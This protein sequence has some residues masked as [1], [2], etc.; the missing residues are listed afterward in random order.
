MFA[1]DTNIF[2]S[3]TN[4]KEAY[5]NANKVLDDVYNYMVTNQLHVNMD[6]SVYMH[7]RPSLNNE[8]RL[9][10]AR[11]RAYGS[12][13]YLKIANKKLK[14][15]DKVKFLGIIIDEQLNW[16]PHIQ[17]LKEKLN[18]AIIM[19]KRIIKFIPKSEY[20]K[21]YEGLFKSHLSYC[22][23]CW[24]AIPNSK[25]QG[26]FTIQKR[27]I[28]LLFGLKYSFDHAGYYETCARSR[29]YQDHTSPKNYVLEHTKS[30]FNKQKILNLFNLYVYHTFISTYKILKTRAPISLYSLFN[31][32][33]RDIGFLLHPP[34]VAL[35]ISRNN[36]V[37][38][39]CHL[40][41]KLIN[42]ILEKSMPDDKGIIIIGSSKNSDFCASIPFVQQKLKANL[43]NQQSQGDI[44]WLPE[45]S[46]KR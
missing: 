2:V 9:T 43:L 36:F 7:F 26:L 4:E 17:H 12:D 11:A 14:K 40:W 44:E 6:K 35:D 1:D 24:G 34:I 8:E 16:E 25:L 46:L 38:K 27:C 32:S 30:L 37:F 42:D 15:V 29:T 10:C 22:I 19:I 23:S 20:S 5:A 21:I 3:G 13:S 33:Q 28:R 18:A 45:N 31:Q 41:N 39:S